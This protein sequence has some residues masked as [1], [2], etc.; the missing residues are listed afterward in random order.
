MKI[1]IQTLV[2]HTN[3]G[4]ILQAYALQ[5]VLQRMGHEVV[6]LN[7][8]ENYPSV[9]LFIY[10]ICSL[11]KC[12]C[13]IYILRD[14]RYVLCNPLNH[15]YIVKKEE[16]VDFSLMEQFVNEKLNYS[17]LFRSSRALK[18]YVD[19][20]DFDCFIVGSDQV[21]REIYVPNIYDS[22]LGYLSKEN[23]AKKIAYAASFGTDDN[24]ISTPKLSACIDLLK[25]FNFISVRE[26][27]AVD[28]CENVFSVKSVHVLDPTMLLSIDDYRMIFE[29]NTIYRSP[30][31]LLTYVLDEKEYINNIIA[32]FSKQQNL[33][34]FSV[35][36]LEKVESLFYTYRQSSLE[37]W[38]R[39]F[40]DAEF[41]ITDSFHAC[42]F[43]ILFN[44]PFVCLGNKSRGNARFESLLGMFG[45][46]NRVVDEISKLESVFKT[47]IDW[48]QV[49]GI[50]KQQRK[51][52]MFFLERALYGN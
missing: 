26:K 23:K 22:F 32:Q 14:K 27:T 31:T 4:C 39:G 51:K 48:N 36:A 42:V 43:S 20:Q 12:L 21:W 38:L 34:P 47:P 50:I 11:I 17:P 49:N 5:T 19:K 8:R 52:S 46:R 37:A 29:A 7:R 16:S 6:I 3:Y 1:A 35:N 18:K 33:V 28:I 2:G 13:R 40:H 25:R 15:A 44:K 10:R 9:K 41:V 45:L 30:G 24:P